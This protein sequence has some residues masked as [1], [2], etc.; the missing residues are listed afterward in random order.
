MSTRL[1]IFAAVT[2]SLLSSAPA[3]ALSA[4]EIAGEYSGVVDNGSF[5]TSGRFRLVVG[6]GGHGSVAVRLGNEPACVVFIETEGWGKIISRPG[7]DPGMLLRLIFVTSP[8]GNPTVTGEVEEDGHTYT[9]EAQKS[10]TTAGLAEGR[11]T[12]MVNKTAGGGDMGSGYA[13]VSA[14]GR[15]IGALTVNGKRPVTFGGRI[16]PGQKLLIARR[17][18]GDGSSVVGTLLFGVTATTGSGSFHSPESNQAL[19]VTGSP[20]DRGQHAIHNTE[21]TFPLVVS[22]NGAAAGAATWRTDGTIGGG[23]LLS[24]PLK[25]AV[26]RSTGSVT[27][28]SGSDILR[29]VVL[30]NE[31]RI[32]GLVNGIA[33]FAVSPAAAQ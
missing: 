33:S 12:F 25:I 21:S 9:V 24:K 19:R 32:A 6:K 23:S 31:N 17:L 1:S 8:D 18:G 16:S 3:F 30:Q 28:K 14:N 10:A 26:N 7:G 29:G 22:L 4:T 15:A 20:Y 5:E 11:H 13:R 27:G 2:I